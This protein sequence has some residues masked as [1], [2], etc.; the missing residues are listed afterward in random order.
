MNP[1]ILDTLSLIYLSSGF[2]SDQKYYSLS[3][4]LFNSFARSSGSLVST[5]F[6][7]IDTFTKHVYIAQLVFCLIDLAL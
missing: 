5:V 2:I 3:F 1:W 6:L 4:D 7:F